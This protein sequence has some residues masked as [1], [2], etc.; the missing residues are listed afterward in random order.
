MTG[1]G[2]SGGASAKGPA[3]SDAAIYPPRPVSRDGSPWAFAAVVA[4]SNPTETVHAL[5]ALILQL[6]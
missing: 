6:L 2:A 1:G 3:K 5:K 4:N